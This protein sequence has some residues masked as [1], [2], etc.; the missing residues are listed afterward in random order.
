[1]RHLA[2]ALR[3]LGV[4]G[5]VAACRPAS[6]PDEASSAPDAPVQASLITDV[7]PFIGTGGHGHTYPGPQWPFGMVQVGPDTRLEGWDGCSGY[8]HDD[9]RVYG[10]SHTH[11]LGTGISDYADILF[12]PSTRNHLA[13]DPPPEHD[14]YPFSSKFSHDRESAHAGSYT[15]TLDDSRIDVELTATPRVGLHRYRYP[16]GEPRFVYVDLL[17]RDALLESSFEVV[18][19]YTIVGH[20]RSRGW[21]RDQMVYFAARFSEPIVGH[22][23]RTALIDDVARP[24][25]AVVELAAGE[26]DGVVV[27]V[28]ISAVDVEGARKNLDAEAGHLRFDEHR[29]AAE[30]AWE[31]ELGRIRVEGG[32]PDQ[33]TLFYTSLY[34]VF[35]VPNLF[36]DVDRRYRGMDGGVHQADHDVYTVFSLW[37]TFRTAHPLDVLVQPER[38]V[39]FVRTMLRHHTDGGRLPVWELA[40]NYTGTMIGYHAVSV[41]S[42]AWMKGLRGFDPEHALTA[43]VEIAERDELGKRPFAAR[44]FIAADEEPESVSKTLEYA[45]DDWAI[46]RMAEDVGGHDEV[47][48]K[49]DRRASG[50]RNLFD[51]DTGFFRPRRNGGFVTPFDPAEVTF[52]F[53]EANAWQYAFFV[54][55]DVAGLAQLHGGRETLVGRLNALFE[56]PGS[57]HGRQQADITGLIGQYAHGNE[58]SHH[59]AWLYP[60]LDAAPEGQRRVREILDSLYANA[61]DG[62]SGNEDCGQMSA[63]YVMSALGLYPVAPGDPHYAIGTPL[64]DRATIRLEE[65]SALTIDARGEG[66]FVAGASL[67]DTPLASAR[68]DHARVRQGGTLT[69]DRSSSPQPD[70]GRGTFA[71]LASSAAASD[72]VRAPRLRAPG[73]GDSLPQ[74]FDGRLEVAY[75]PVP[76]GCAIELSVNGE[77]LATVPETLV[78]EETSD[79]SARTVC[80]PPSGSEGPRASGTVTSRF[81]RR[82]EGLTLTMEN[83]WHPQYPAGG[84]TA[85]I[86][87]IRGGGDFRTGGW[88][89]IYA[90]DLRAT[91]ELDR[92]TKVRAI[93]LG[94]LQDQRSW[95]WMPRGVDVEVSSD[96][97]RWT[98]IGRMTHD[99]AEDA[100]GVVIE[101]LELPIGRR[102]RFVRIRAE[103][104]DTIPDWHPGRGNPAFIFADEIE[105]VR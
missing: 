101:R 37:D 78:L 60:L 20:R 49:F 1:M 105:L 3:V 68:L 24:A 81:V 36:S 40:G 31:S 104:V 58:P 34:R 35:S 72:F 10:F 41:I 88:Q 28:G 15:V 38:S 87:G 9:D 45:Y 99:V 39:D 44:G 64:F 95:I 91:I 98:S 51:P 2:Y 54:P 73:N 71:E 11:L 53:T 62:L 7:N 74:S 77:A 30:A 94:L 46:A 70:W 67:G 66:A 86:D 50:W 83:S 17:H 63:W 89:G 27:A 22:V 102:V 52:D 42:D 76:E 33:R 82:P 100:E 43:M 25:E 90:E 92:A 57:L 97:K 29:A 65:G 14:A 80:S 21:A 93:R 16:E 84:A 18:D 4:V 48:A 47:V 96:G 23:V 55:H 5:L 85:L 61:P 59:F 26:G 103:I 75:A 56:A 19:E 69:I 6:G 32:T 13:D 12:M 79:L 8:H